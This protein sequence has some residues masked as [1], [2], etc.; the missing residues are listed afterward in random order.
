MKL[1]NILSKKNKV[2]LRELVKT[3]FKLRYQA[4]ILGYAWSILKPLFLFTIM[5]IVFVHFLRFGEGIEHFAPMLLLGI[6]L[7][8]FFVETTKQGMN[9]IVSKGG[10]M[11]KINFPKYI[12]VI[13][14]SISAL[15]NL[16]IN[17]VVVFVFM[18]VDGVSFGPGIIV[19]P[20]F[21]L[22]L[23]AFSLSIAFLFAAVSVK[24]RD[25][26]YIWDILLQAG[27]YGTA[28]FY[29]LQRV[30]EI[31]LTAAQVMILNPMAYIIQGSRASLVGGEDVLTIGQLYNNPLWAIIPLAV[32]ALFAV[33][34]VWYFRKHSPRFAEEV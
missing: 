28:I 33:V 34:A 24:F 26:G 14:T 1:K 17:L 13:S 2:L 10:L 3:D 21:L 23:Y 5:Y 11:R 12:L 29:P 16:G 25:I 9:A 15:I 27:F 32:M 30:A 22:L 8:N 4:S 31:S 7:W 20:V 18:L 19:F 6:V